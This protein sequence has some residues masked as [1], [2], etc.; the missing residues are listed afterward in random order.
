MADD[1]LK[2]LEMIQ[3]AISRMAAN[4]FLLKG[5]SVTLTSAI[6]GLAVKDARP[7]IA[8][9]AIV[10]VVVFAGLDA[11]YLA[12]ERKFR[13]LWQPAVDNQA[14]PPL[15]RM[16]P[17]AVTRSDWWEAIKRPAVWGLHLPL[18]FAAYVVYCILS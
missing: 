6:L 15:F 11:Y 7:A 5:W 2:Y 13:S 1:R 9:V 17:G 18:A 10:P 3:A 14:T 4:S 12:L 8:L 16:S